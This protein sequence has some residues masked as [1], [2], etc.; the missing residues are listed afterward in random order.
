MWNRIKSWF[1]ANDDSRTLFDGG[2]EHEFKCYDTAE[3]YEFKWLIPVRKTHYQS[4][5]STYVI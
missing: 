3:E 2:A 1:G 4:A 5:F